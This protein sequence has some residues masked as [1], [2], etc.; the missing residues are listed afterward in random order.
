MD[1]QNVLSSSKSF[2]RHEL[3]CP[4]EKVSRLTAREAPQPLYTPAYE[5]KDSSLNQILIIGGVKFRI[6]EN[7][8]LLIFQIKQNLKD[9]HISLV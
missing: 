2:D 4:M 6:G 3:T 9:S 7:R 5:S 1:S 8:Q